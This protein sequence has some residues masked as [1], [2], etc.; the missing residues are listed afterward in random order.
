MVVL[1]LAVA[2]WFVDERVAAGALVEQIRGLTGA[3]GAEVVEQ[4][5]QAARFPTSGG[6]AGY[7]RSAHPCWPVPRQ[8][9]RR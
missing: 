7:R 6:L 4:V 1:V 3:R 2:A 5:I 9:L 8:L